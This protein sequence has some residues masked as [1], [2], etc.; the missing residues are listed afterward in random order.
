[1]LISGSQLAS[2]QMQLTY[3][4]FQTE[5]IAATKAVNFGI[6]RQVSE[7]FLLRVHK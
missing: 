3:V 4:L 6:S 1:M 2:V 5:I 7:S